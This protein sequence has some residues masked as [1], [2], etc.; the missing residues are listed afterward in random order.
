VKESKK[1]ELG[2]CTKLRK[3]QLNSSKNRASLNIPT[4]RTQFQWL[5]RRRRRRMH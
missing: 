3:T 4:K 5:R 1:K 2:T